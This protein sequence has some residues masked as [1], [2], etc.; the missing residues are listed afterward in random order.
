MD[1]IVRG[2]TILSKYD[3]TGG[4]VSVGRERNIFA[5]P[6]DLH[7]ADISLPDCVALEQRGWY[8]DDEIGRWGIHL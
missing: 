5:G 3:D 6:E 1:D 7:L 2:F 4:D 8:V